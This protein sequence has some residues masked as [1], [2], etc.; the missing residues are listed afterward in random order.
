MADRITTTASLEVPQW[1]CT[2]CGKPLAGGVALGDGRGLCCLRSK[3]DV[4]LLKSLIGNAVAPDEVDS[5][6]KRQ[7]LRPNP[8]VYGIDELIDGVDNEEAGR[9]EP[10]SW[11][12]GK[13]VNAAGLGPPALDAGAS[14]PVGWRKSLR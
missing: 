3:A 9:S 11:T 1:R 6:R 13:G 8:S 14:R 2:G 7:T 5:T 4:A 10:K 12:G